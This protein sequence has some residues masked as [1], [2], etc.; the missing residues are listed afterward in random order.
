MCSWKGHGE[1]GLSVDF[2]FSGWEDGQ[3]HEHILS[4]DSGNVSTQAEDL[5]E[6]VE[7]C[8]L[9]RSVWIFFQPGMSYYK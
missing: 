2:P 9:V 7:K 4:G 5:G 6:S 8:H 1:A 3:L